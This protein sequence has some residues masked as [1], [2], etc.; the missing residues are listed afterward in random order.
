MCVWEAENERLRKE[1]T[2]IALLMLVP[3]SYGQPV[4]GFIAPLDIVGGNLIEGW[5]GT[6]C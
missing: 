6:T 3:L 1:G 2:Y 5:E 4:N